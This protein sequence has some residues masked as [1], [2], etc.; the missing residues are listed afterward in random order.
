MRGNDR[1]LVEFRFT[2][3]LVDGLPDAVLLRLESEALR[4]NR[5]NGL[6]GE[7]RLSGRTLR[8]VIEGS[9]L[10]VMPLAARIL[11]DRRHT[12]IAVSAFRPIE[13]RRFA[14]WT[15]AGF[16][17]SSS[18]LDRDLEAR[19]RLLPAAGAIAGA[20]DRVMRTGAT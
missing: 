5:L 18:P 16:K 1:A 11:T 14:A 17:L 15:S 7:M 10:V 3:R 6:T 4:F 9:W 13:A 19:L 12:A 20:A 2:S 8:Q